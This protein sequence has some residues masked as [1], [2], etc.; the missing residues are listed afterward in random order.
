MIISKMPHVILKRFYGQTNINL[1]FLFPWL[2]WGIDISDFEKIDFLV[3]QSIFSISKSYTAV[4][5]YSSQ[6]VKENFFGGDG[7]KF[8]YRFHKNREKDRKFTY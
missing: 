4:K 6:H 2:D 8:Q 7:I 3:D 5:R 1:I